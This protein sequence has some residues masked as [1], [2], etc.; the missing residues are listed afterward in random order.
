M[1]GRAGVLGKV[2]VLGEM[3]GRVGVLCRVGC[4]LEVEY[5]VEWGVLGRVRAWVE[6]ECQAIRVL[7]RAE[8]L[9]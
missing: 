5:C 7:G 6:L 4:Q 1:L 9:G 8:V 3:L 2:G